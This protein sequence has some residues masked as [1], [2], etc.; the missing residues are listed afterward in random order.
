MRIEDSLFKYQ[1]V[2]NT[3]TDQNLVTNYSDAATKTDKV[4][5]AN[6][7]QQKMAA[8]ELQ[9]S[10][11]AQQ[12]LEQREIELSGAD[13]EKLDQAVRKA[14]EKGVDNTLVLTG[15]E[16]FIINTK[17][18]VVITVISGDDLKENVFTQID[19]AVII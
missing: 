10:K 17:N 1:G 7:L 16:A 11:H 12:R 2:L 19:G 15:K 6:L 14:E 13:L 4:S 5:F 18:N 3:F 9:F 8:S